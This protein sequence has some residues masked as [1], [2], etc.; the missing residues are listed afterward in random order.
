MPPPDTI[1]ITHSSASNTIDSIVYNTDS[2]ISIPASV[3]GGRYTGDSAG[4]EHWG[5]FLLVGFVFFG[6]IMLIDKV[7]KGLAESKKSISRGEVADVVED[8]GLL[9]HDWLLKCNPYY[10]S[11]SLAQQQLFLGRVVSVMQSKQFQYH[12]ITAE[13]YIPVLISGAAV[14]LTFGLKNYL[15]AYF[16]TIHVMKKEYV[17]SMDNET[18]YG[19]VSKTGIHVSW[20][21]FMYG[22][23]N[24]SDAVNVGLHEMAH[25]LQFDAYL[26]FECSNDRDLKV[27]LNSYCEEGRPIFRAMRTGMS[28]FLDEY[29]MTNFDEFWAVSVENFFENSKTFKENLPALYQEMCDLLNQDPL[30]PHKII[31]SDLV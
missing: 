31:N 18:Y 29:A 11:L 26:G 28:L 15:L 7:R 23:S 25:A 27:R 12:S 3:S 22:Y 6:I 17:L 4:K 21:H 24:Y 10:V 16:D 30:L 19:H 2:A 20:S 8:K 1:I 5:A 13:E 9:Y 14:Q